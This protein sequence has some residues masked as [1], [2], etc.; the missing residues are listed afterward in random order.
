MIGILDSGLGGLSTWLALRQDFPEANFLYLA[1]QAYAPYG[2]QREDTL[3]WRLQWAIEFFKKRK[4][5]ALVLACGTLSAVAYPK[6]QAPFPFPIFEA[7]TPAVEQ[8]VGLCPKGVAVLATTASIRSNAYLHLLKE[9]GVEE[10]VQRACPLF[11]PL[12][13]EGISPYSVATKEILSHYISPIAHAPYNVLL[14]G[15]THFSFLSEAISSLCPAMQLIDGGRALAH[16]M[17]LQYT[18]REEQGKTLFY[19]TGSPTAFIQKTSALL[20]RE[21]LTVYGVGK[22]IEK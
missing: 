3:L 15:C 4:V 10:V 18:P 14:L 2:E 17:K 7:I 22:G 19:T 9:K 1:D 6:L 5:E 11:V 20:P 16:K 12:L 21:R 8:A 13:E